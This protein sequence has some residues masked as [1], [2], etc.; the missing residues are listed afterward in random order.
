ML[1]TQD[2]Q[3]SG[4]EGTEYYRHC[5]TGYTYYSVIVITTRY[6]TK[7]P[8]KPSDFNSSSLFLPAIHGNTWRGQAEAPNICFPYY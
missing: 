3:K 5:Q 4:L 1:H 2:T 8:N 7:N 6:V